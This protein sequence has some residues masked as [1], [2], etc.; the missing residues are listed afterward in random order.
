MERIR[1]ED[2]VG[3]EWAEWY[4]MTPEQRWRAQDAMWDTYL[5]LGGSLGPEP[6]PQ[7][8]FFDPDDLLMGGQACV[9]CGAAEFSRNLDL[10]V[11][12]EP[13]NPTPPNCCGF[14]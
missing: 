13:E 7:S 9:L 11:L 12:A 6:D 8:P 1:A 3:E 14:C 4:A 10:C 5:M 2:L